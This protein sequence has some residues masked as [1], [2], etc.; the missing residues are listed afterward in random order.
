MEKS[1][2]ITYSGEN[3]ILLFKNPGYYAN[4]EIQVIVP[5]T[6]EVI[7]IKNGRMEE[8]LKPGS[9]TIKNKNDLYEFIFV[10]MTNTCQLKWGTTSKVHLIDPK[11]NIPIDIG[12]YGKYLITMENQRKLTLKLLSDNELSLD[13]VSEY[14]RSKINYI[15]K[16]SLVTKVIKDKINFFEIYNN[17]DELKKGILEELKPFFKDA[18]L[19]LIDFTIDNISLDD[20]GKK[21]IKSSYLEKSDIKLE[22]EHKFCSN[23]GAKVSK[24]DKFCKE[25]GEKL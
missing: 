8:S 5:P 6:H 25:C 2:R 18:G 16:E 21:V 15:F 19:N 3:D 20:E 23:C 4:K 11:D 9:T 22:T 24:T 1:V 12:A 7:V 13:N 17:L 10:N 14:F